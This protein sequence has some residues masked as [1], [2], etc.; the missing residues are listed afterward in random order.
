MML[1]PTDQKIFTIITLIFFTHHLPLRLHH[2]LRLHL[3]LHLHLHHIHVCMLVCIIIILYN[4]VQTVPHVHKRVVVIIT[5]VNH[6]SILKFVPKTLATSLV[7]LLIVNSDKSTCFAN[8]FKLI[9]NF[10]LQI[11]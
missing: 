2:P 4:I 3:H 9:S 7:F 6:F 5:W 11:Q 8:S 1:K 10:L